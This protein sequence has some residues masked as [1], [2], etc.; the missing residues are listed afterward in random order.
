VEYE[1]NLT[2][3]PQKYLDGKSRS[4]D[5]ARVVGGGSVINGMCWTRGSA[6]DYDAWEALGNP[7]WGWHGLLPY[8]KKVQLV[9]HWDVQFINV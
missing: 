2:T 5:M 1:W 9:G 4:Y 8:F 3:V 7:G 6:A